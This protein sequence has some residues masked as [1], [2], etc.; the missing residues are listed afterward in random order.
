[1]LT[2]AIDTCCFYYSVALLRESQVLFEI[3]SYEQNMQC[4]ELVCKIESLLERSS[5]S[6]RELDLIAVTSG[7]G[8]FNGVRIGMSAAYGISLATG[9]KIVTVSTLEVMAY[10]EKANALCF[11]PDSQVGF[12]QRFDRKF[13]PM[14]EI[15]EVRLDELTGE[16]LVFDINGYDKSQVSNG[17]IAGLIAIQTGRKQST[18]FYGKPPSIHVKNPG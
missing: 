18:L 16:V 8:T 14:S 4:E 6:Y 11:T 12:F 7:P 5:L 15:S 3:R 2:L 17:V 13:N 9:A 1:M 10:K